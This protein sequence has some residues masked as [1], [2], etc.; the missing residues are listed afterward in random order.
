[1]TGI[2]NERGGGR[3]KDWR[4][5]KVDIY[6][7][8]SQEIRARKMKKKVEWSIAGGKEKC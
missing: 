1:M 2:K 5:K 6:T 8:E 4:I 3:P 7:D